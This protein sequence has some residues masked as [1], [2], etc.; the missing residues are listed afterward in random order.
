MAINSSDKK[1]ILTLAQGGKYKYRGN[2][3]QY[4][5]TRII[6]FKITMVIYCGIVL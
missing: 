1:K 3:P 5:K 2:L 6:R 4:F